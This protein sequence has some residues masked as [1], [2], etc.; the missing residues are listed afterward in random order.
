MDRDAA[1]PATWQYLFLVVA[2]A[3]AVAVALVLGALASTITSV[4]L[5]FG[6]VKSPWGSRSAPGWLRGRSC[7]SPPRCGW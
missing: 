4:V 1:L 6:P 7:G 2:V 3:V 5:A